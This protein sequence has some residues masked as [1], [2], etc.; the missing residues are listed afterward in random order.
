MRALE[1]SLALCLLCTAHG[2]SRARAQD[3]VESPVD[4][5]SVDEPA[6][7]GSDSPEPADVD[8]PPILADSSVDDAESELDAEAAPQLANAA[9]APPA[10]PEWGLQLGP[11]RFA[12]S[13]EVWLRG[14]TRVDPPA[15]SGVEEYFVASRIR[16][17][18][19]VRWDLVRLFVQAQ[20]ARTFGQF[21]PGNGSGATTSFQQGWV[22]LGGDDLFVRAGRQ[23][24]ALGGERMIGPLLWAN[25]ARA[26]DALR[27]HG[28]WGDVQA[29][30]LGAFVQTPRTVPGA[31]SGPPV[32]SEGDYLGVA[33]IAWSPGPELVAE[34]YVLFRHDGPTEAPPGAPDPNVFLARERNIAHFAVRATGRLAD[35]VDYELEAMVQT[36][37]AGA[38]EHLALGLVANVG[39]RLGTPAGLG[40]RGGVDYG[41]G[42]SPTGDLDELDNFFP[43]NHLFY[44]YAD[45]FGL[46]NVIDGWARLIAAPPGVSQL[47]LWLDGHLFAFAE[48]T[49]RWS[50]A[51]GA[52]L[53]GP[54][55]GG[56]ALAGGEIDLELRWTP[57]DS[58]F[59]WS[60]YALFI[61]ADGARAR[62][63][64]DLS[65]WAYL[66]VG[67]RLP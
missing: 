8:V 65:H 5:A 57:V 62:G 45:H 67:A 10:T 61:P 63:V 6:T 46:R 52:T 28:R 21:A 24:Y 34:P 29:D 35:V 9:P 17:G 15:R 39:A 30:V 38:R 59:V 60:G 25:A 27:L 56:D 42:D 31:T 36:G 66:M 23:E 3:L 13:A 20:D 40:I 33:R 41:S 37:R 58:F 18:L 4:S 1:L 55:S 16:L 53:A 50:N 64:R 43:T 7:P 22:Q 19:E 32:A 14:E 2:P 48:P 11:V 54:T 47:R 12:P 49:A 26:F 44:G 51:A